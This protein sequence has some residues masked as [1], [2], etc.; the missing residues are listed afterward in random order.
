MFLSIVV[1]MM[2]S[3]IPAVL[4]MNEI[5]AL[6]HVALWKKYG[7]NHMPSAVVPEVE[8]P[9]PSSSRT[10]DTHQV[11]CSP[12][13]PCTSRPEE[14][15]SPTHGGFLK[16]I[17]TEPLEEHR[18]LVST[19]SMS[20]KRSRHFRWNTSLTR[21]LA[22][23]I[24]VVECLTEKGNIDHVLAERAELGPFLIE[25][26]E[27]PVIDNLTA[28]QGSSFALKHSCLSSFSS[29]QNLS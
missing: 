9:Q 2:L 17:E 23:S 26:I 19:P 25:S 1:F 16:S 24:A 20:C 3:L 15:T 28:F 6:G 27:R 10:T 29:F 4:T 13:P 12:S 11:P 18:E 8:A 21:C 14:R 22:V 5:S 7:S